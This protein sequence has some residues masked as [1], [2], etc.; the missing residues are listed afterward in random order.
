M[1]PGLSIDPAVGNTPAW[2]NQR[3][4]LIAI[5]DGELQ[6]LIEAGRCDGFPH[7]DKDS[8]QRNAAV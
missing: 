1:L 6:V 4:D 7:G 2:E 3:M 5:Y 8:C